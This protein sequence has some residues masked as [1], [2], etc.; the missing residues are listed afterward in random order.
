M[1]LKVPNDLLMKENGKDNQSPRKSASP[2]LNSM[3]T[4]MLHPAL[5]IHTEDEDQIY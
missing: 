4:S 3:M 2:N 5:E 1:P